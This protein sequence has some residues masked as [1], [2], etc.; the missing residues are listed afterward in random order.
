MNNSVQ[1]LATLHMLSK[2]HV[3]SKV[4]FGILNEIRFPFHSFGGVL[5]G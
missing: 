1:P 5:L 3:G 2:K 4:G